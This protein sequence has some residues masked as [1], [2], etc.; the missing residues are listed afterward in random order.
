VTTVER[1]HAR[2]AVT[3]GLVDRARADRCARTH[4][5]SVR[6]A[7]ALGGRQRGAHPL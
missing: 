3:N 1:V 2:I 5:M 7:S 4:S 6:A